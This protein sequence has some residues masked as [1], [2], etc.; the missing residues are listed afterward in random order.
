MYNSVFHYLGSMKVWIWPGVLLWSVDRFAR[1][2]RLVLINKLWI[3]PGRRRDLQLDETE[4][5]LTGPASMMITV[6]RPGFTW[7]AGQHV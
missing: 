2:G 7:K 5:R 3:M 4:M 1:V 6:K